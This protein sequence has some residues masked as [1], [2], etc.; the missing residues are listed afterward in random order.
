MTANLTTLERH[1][2]LLLRAYPVGYRRQRAEEMLGTLLD[3]TPPGRTW[4][5]P[6]DVIALLLG[7]LRARSGQDQRFSTQASLRMAALLGCASYLTFTALNYASYGLVPGVLIMHSATRR[8]ANGLASVWSMSDGRASLPPLIVAPVIL[9]AAL[10]PWFASRKIV[11]LG[12]ALAG[13]ATV[14]FD[15][16]TSAAHN[17]A[18]SPDPQILQIV[19]PLAALVLLTSRRQRPPRLWLWLPGLVVALSLVLEIGTLTEIKYPWVSA[20]PDPYL[21]LVPLAVVVVWFGVDARP[22]VALA[23]YSGLWS[24]QALINYWHFHIWAIN[25][26]GGFWN[27]DPWVASQWA[28]SPMWIA[29]VLALTAVAMWRVRRQAV[30]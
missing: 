5:L 4:P 19:A 2:R 24:S 11:A 28:D 16:L 22:A 1:S 7:G 9:A 13:T 15:V 25:L 12:A 30:L 8:T 20:A 27:R 26:A 21:W 10:L 14:T 23:V 18:T 29:A 17:W 3:T 6:R